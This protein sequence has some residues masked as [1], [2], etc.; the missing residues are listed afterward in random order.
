MVTLLLQQSEGEDDNITLVIIAVRSSV[1]HWFFVKLDQAQVL[2]RGVRLSLVEEPCRFAN[3]TELHN[4]SVRTFVKVLVADLALPGVRHSSITQK[5]IVLAVAAVSATGT[6][7]DEKFITLKTGGYPRITVS[8]NGST[9]K[10]GSMKVGLRP[11]LTDFRRPGPG[12]VS[13]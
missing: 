10:L 4:L 3:S 9:L 7:E 11:P 1:Q 6:H 8:L 2:V 12:P 13:G 5:A